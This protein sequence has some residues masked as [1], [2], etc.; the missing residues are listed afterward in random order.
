MSEEFKARPSQLIPEILAIGLAGIL[1]YVLR[2]SKAP[3]EPITFFPETA[4]GITLN[5]GIFVVLMATAGTVI[6]L[7]VK[8]GFKQ[9]VRYLINI[10]L[11]GLLFFLFTWYGALYSDYLPKTLTADAWI[12]ISVTATA[13]L[14][15]AIFKSKGVLHFGGIV[16]I[17]G[18]TGTFLGVSIPTLTAIALLLALAG[19]DLFAVYRGPIGKIAQS[20]DLEEFTGAVFTYGDLTVGMGDMVFY[21]MLASNSMMNFGPVPFL[22]ASAGLVIGAFLGFKMLEGREMFPGLPF[23]ILL[24]LGLMFA[25]L[26]IMNFIHW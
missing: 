25:L 10:A 15:L 7:F 20:A 1:T 14:A 24:G 4:G 6:Y 5:A 23:A 17:G 22:G 18:L 19:Y 9:I 2:I 13:L 21:S 26:E 12:L 8:F 3:I 11:L 16:L